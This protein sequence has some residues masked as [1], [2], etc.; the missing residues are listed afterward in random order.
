[1]T[2]YKVSGEIKWSLVVDARDEYGAKV[3]AYN[4]V[5]PKH[6]MWDSLDPDDFEIEEVQPCK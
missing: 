3:T 6:L 5:A 4:R 1:M 2:L